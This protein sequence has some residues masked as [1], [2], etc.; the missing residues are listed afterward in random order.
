[1]AIFNLR[2]F[3]FFL[4]EILCL[5]SGLFS[6]VNF[7]LCQNCVCV[8]YCVRSVAMFLVNMLFQSL[9]FVSLLFQNIL[10]AFF[11]QC[12]CVVSGL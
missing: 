2:A 8:L 6:C 7:V 3:F 10:F 9:Y 5:V 12:V 11:F 4:K 1:M